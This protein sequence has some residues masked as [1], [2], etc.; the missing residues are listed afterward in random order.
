M[1]AEVGMS[2]EDMRL[3]KRLAEAA[4]GVYREAALGGLPSHAKAAGPG[5]VL[6]KTARGMSMLRVLALQDPESGEDAAAINLALTPLPGA[7]EA[8]VAKVR[9][10]R[11]RVEI[12]NVY[13]WEVPRAL[14]MDEALMSNIEGDVWRRR[15]EALYG[16][17]VAEIGRLEGGFTV[18][19]TPDSWCLAIRHDASGAIV[20]WVNTVLGRVDIP[21]GWQRKWGLEVPDEEAVRSAVGRASELWS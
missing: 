20:A 17:S 8:I 18:L 14:A 12:I 21:V 19:R 10:K 11:S 13:P 3:Q 16:G 5:Y 6:A 1:G 7:G 9:I 2:L 4:V 15:L